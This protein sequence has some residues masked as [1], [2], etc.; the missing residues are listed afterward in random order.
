[1]LDDTCL[2]AGLIRLAIG[3]ERSGPRLSIAAVGPASFRGMN[4][5][6]ICLV[7]SICNINYLPWPYLVAL[8]RGRDRLW[9]KEGRYPISDIR[10]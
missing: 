9:T 8:A 7:C 1:M 3:A 5:C 10:A 4:T 2:A 6:V